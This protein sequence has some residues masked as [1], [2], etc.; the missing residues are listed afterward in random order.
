MMDRTEICSHAIQ[1]FYKLLVMPLPTIPA[2]R[3]PW[4]RYFLS[5]D[6]RPTTLS[7]DRLK[8]G[9]TSTSSTVRYT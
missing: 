8:T 3:T 7:T 1:T 9:A 4:A 2:S 6:A 5:L